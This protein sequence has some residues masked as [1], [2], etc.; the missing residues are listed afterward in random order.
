MGMFDTYIPKP[1]LP[2]P[3]CGASHLEWQSRDGPR[4]LFVW[5][6]GRPAPAGQRVV[7][8]SVVSPKAR[9]EIRLPERF[10]IYATCACPTFLNAVGFTED[11]VW[12]RTEL[13]S[14]ANAVAYHHESEREFR[15]RLAALAEHLGHSSESRD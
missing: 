1:D 11:G 15:K 4:A 3:V 8:E 5:E 6:Q 10:E 9:A 12:T 13:L 14:A 2:C 7:D